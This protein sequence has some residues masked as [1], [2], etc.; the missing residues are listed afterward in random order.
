MKTSE[1]TTNRT[2]RSHHWFIPCAAALALTCAVSRPQLASADGAVVV[3]AA[4][5]N[6]NVPSG[7]TAYL[8]GHASGTQD[9]ICMPCPNAITTAA[10][11]PASGFAWAFYGPQATLFSVDDGDDQQIITHF[12]SPNPAEAGKPR[13][14]WQ[15]SQDTSAVWANNTSPPAQSS[16]D[17][18]F[19]AADAIPWLL[20]PVAGTQAGPTGGDRLTKTTYIQRLD[21][22][23]GV[24]PAASTC[25]AADS[26]KK[27]LVPY[28]ADYFF[29]KAAQPWD[30]GNIANNHCN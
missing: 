12:L 4:P 17:P 5:A 19:V 22:A 8:V 10:T 25:T 1:M 9:Y 2:T 6:L 16:T 3:P 23:G 15:D 13:P 24:A 28:S 29:Y 20:L 11:C 18:A 14:T 26:G 21:T 30:Q 27:A 7:N